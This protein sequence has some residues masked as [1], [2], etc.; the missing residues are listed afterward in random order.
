M[1]K[2]PL[3]PTTIAVTWPQRAYLRFRLFLIWTVILRCRKPRNSVR[4]AMVFDHPGGNE[5]FEVAIEIARFDPSA[6]ATIIICIRW[7]TLYIIE[8]N[9]RL[10]D[11]WQ[12]TVA[13]PQQRL[14]A[15]GTCRPPPA[16]AKAKAK[17]WPS[18]PSGITFSKQPSPIDPAHRAAIAHR[19][20]P[21]AG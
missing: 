8:A 17:E 12:S 19:F 7:N 21:P 18:F 13:V 2:A 1:H 14:G 5:P 9:R 3:V 6:P 11:Q 20:G 15:V 4:R 10:M 16:K